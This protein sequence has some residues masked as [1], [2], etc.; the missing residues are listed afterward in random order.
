MDDATQWVTSAHPPAVLLGS[1]YHN[2]MRA[3]D[4][5]LSEVGA[6]HELIDPLAERGLEMPHCFVASERSDEVARDAFERMLAFLADR[7]DVG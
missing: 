4:A 2:D 1:E 7:T 5:A 3:L 6:A